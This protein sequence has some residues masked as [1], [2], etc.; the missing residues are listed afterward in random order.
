[1][2]KRL[3]F[4]FVAFFALGFANCFA[5][6]VEAAGS[7]E[8]ISN[9]IN[10]SKERAAKIQTLLDKRP[11]ECGLPS[12][13]TFTDQVYAAAASCMSTA[14]TL[15]NLYT[16]QVSEPDADGVTSVEITKPKLEDWLNLLA[17]LTSQT[18]NLTAM[19]PAAAGMVGA[20]GEI[21]NPLQIGKAKKSIQSTGDLFKLI[22][23]ENV[24]QV[25]AV[26]GI[27][28]L[29]KSNKNL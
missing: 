8:E 27:I 13:D 26:K 29:L 11:K 4:L 12:I 14:V 22:G 6:E 20:L 10:E 23:Q 21:K 7:P 19:A 2:M 28:S 16:R 17:D 18:V 3:V 1:M 9:E 5:D 15:E 25:K 24:A